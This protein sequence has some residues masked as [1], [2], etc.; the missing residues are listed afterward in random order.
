MDVEFLRLEEVL[1]KFKIS[2]AKLYRLVKTQ[3][4]PPPIK[5]GTAN[6]WLASD[7]ESY[8]TE[9]IEAARNGGVK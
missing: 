4:F 9:Q 8:L 3:E 1:K 6:R 2:Q 5:I 7:L